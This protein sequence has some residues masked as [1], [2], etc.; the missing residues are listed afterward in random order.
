MASPQDAISDED[1]VN[2]A[3]EAYEEIQRRHNEKKKEAL[4]QALAESRDA[5]LAA[6]PAPQF[7]HKVYSKRLPAHGD[8]PNLQDIICCQPCSSSGGDAANDAS[9]TS[10]DDQRETN[11]AAPSA[12]VVLCNRVSD[13]VVS[14]CDTE[15]SVAM[16]SQGK[17]GESPTVSVR[18]RG[19]KSSKPWTEK[20]P[21][22][23]LEGAPETH[24]SG[25]TAIFLKTNIA[26]DDETNLNY[27]PYFGEDDDEDVVSDLYNTETREKMIEVGPEYKERETNLVI[28]DTLALVLSKLGTSPSND[29]TLTQRIR[30][31]LSSVLKVDI[32]RISHVTS[33]TGNDDGSAKPSSARSPSRPQK[34][35]VAK[36]DYLSA[37]DSYRALFCRRCFTYDCNIH[38]LVTKPDA[39]LQAEQA[40]QK[41]R[42]GFWIEVRACEKSSVYRGP[43][44]AI[45]ICEHAF[46]ST[47]Y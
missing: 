40:I 21:A 7:Q 16:L 31:A 29:E 6:L 42:E 8:A 26:G 1:I 33:S 19:S 10:D 23:F 32:E 2:L 44:I 3:K 46:S 15:T 24:P 43:F 17:D 25:T 4:E 22:I 47:P 14:S 13:A 35:A 5:V 38:G 30:E 27:V 11:D 36:S 41:E 34:Q 9:V 45:P 39:Q 12:E 37:E 20:V 18:M 28:Q